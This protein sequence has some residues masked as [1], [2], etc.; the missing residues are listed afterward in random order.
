MTDTS[1]RFSK[2]Q[3]AEWARGRIDRLAENNGFNLDCGWVQVDQ[4]TPESPEQ[5]IRA[6]NRAYGEVMALQ[7]LIDVFNL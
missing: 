6:R 4:S 3:V 2:S 1:K 5:K 7:A